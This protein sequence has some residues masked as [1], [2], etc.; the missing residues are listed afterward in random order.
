MEFVYQVYRE[1]AKNQNNNIRLGNCEVIYTCGHEYRLKS[2]SIIHAKK[3]ITLPILE[4]PVRK[5]RLLAPA[6]KVEEM[7]NSAYVC[8]QEFPFFLYSFFKA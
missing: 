1:V 5:T 6:E 8:F 4:N 3:N 2:L 7:S